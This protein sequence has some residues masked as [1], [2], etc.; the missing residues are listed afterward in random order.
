MQVSRVTPGGP[1]PFLMHGRRVI[2]DVIRL[3]GLDVHKKSISVAFAD[4]GLRGE[5]RYASHRGNKRQTKKRLLTGLV[6]C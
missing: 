5:S 6:K 2:V 4:G 1:V 3:V